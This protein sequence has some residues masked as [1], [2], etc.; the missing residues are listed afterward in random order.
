MKRETKAW[1]HKWLIVLTALI[2][3]GLSGCNQADITN[4]NSSATV[5]ITDCAGR[6]V[7]YP[8]RLNG[9]PACARCGLHDGY[10]WAGR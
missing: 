8:T 9:L 2:I 7:E 4:K 10:V 1:G 3:I 5:S 6:Q